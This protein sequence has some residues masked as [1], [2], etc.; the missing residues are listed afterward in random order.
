MGLHRD[1]LSFTDRCGGPEGALA[2]ARV[3]VVSVNPAEK[4]SPED[5]AQVK[6]GHTLANERFA[7]EVP[8]DAPYVV[9]AAAEGLAPVVVTVDDVKEAL[10]LELNSGIVVEGVVSDGRTAVPLPG[11][12]VR[13]WP[14]G[15]ELFRKRGAEGLVS[16]QAVSGDDGRYSLP[17][18]SAGLWFVEGWAPGMVL[19]V[20][21]V[22]F[23]FQDPRAGPLP[24][25]RA[26]GEETQ[27]EVSLP[28]PHCP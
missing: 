26:A 8:G 13:A 20:V 27:K 14:K 21:D 18:L 16:F 5:L 10:L 25:G 7:I 15:V 19:S 12:T 24:S 1:D 3:V 11:A 28:E 17:N 9:F 2:G 4:E 22:S 6:E 23:G